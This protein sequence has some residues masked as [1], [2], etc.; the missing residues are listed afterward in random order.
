MVSST[1]EPMRRVL[2]TGA[3]GL[4]GGILRARLAD[5][6]HFRYLTRSRERYSDVW[7]DIADMAIARTA[8]RGV[9]S[10]VHL[11][12]A[13]SVSSPWQTVLGSNIV[14]T[15]NILEAA[16]EAQVRQVILASSNH[17]VGDHEADLAPAVYEAGVRPGLSVDLPPRPD[18]LYGVSKAFGEVL[19]RYYADRHGIHVVCLRI[20]SVRSDD[21]PFAET[22][23][24]IEPWSTFD[25]LTRRRR[26][27]AVWLSHRDCA[28]LI[29]AALEATNVPWCIA[30]GVSDNEGRFW[31]LEPGASLLGWRPA[32]GARVPTT[33]DFP[34]L[35]AN[36][37]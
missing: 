15:R 17:V 14:G 18:S 11:A 30:Y 26:Q 33:A 19:G 13:A 4:I 10:V 31:D 1:S 2:I 9:D 34:G 7:G 28:S 35:A 8:V 22:G 16:R 23:F 12:G 21:D 36:A 5:R 25:S 24:S 29:A 27:A 37:G 6:Y 32:D 20:G 3:E